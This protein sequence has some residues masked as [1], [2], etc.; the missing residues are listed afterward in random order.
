MVAAHT[1]ALRQERQGSNMMRRRYQVMRADF[2][3]I[4]EYNCY[5]RAESYYS[6]HKDARFIWDSWKLEIVC[7]DH[8]PCGCEGQ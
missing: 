1:A 7:M 2:V 8:G 4:M 3:S 6:W 5:E